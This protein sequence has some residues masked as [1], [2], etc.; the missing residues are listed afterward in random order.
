MIYVCKY[1]R[2]HS[3]WV[4]SH[5]FTPDLSDINFMSTATVPTWKSITSTPSNRMPINHM[6]YFVTRIMQQ[7][8]H[9]CLV[10][11]PSHEIVCSKHFTSKRKCKKLDNVTLEWF[12]KKAKSVSTNWVC[13][14]PSNH[15]LNHT[16]CIIKHFSDSLIASECMYRIILYVISQCS[17]HDCV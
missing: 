13:L 8:I 7:H 3:F 4:I 10:A 16:F 2:S 5:R 17:L 14:R 6:Q 9:E 1:H 12:H 15:T 11:T